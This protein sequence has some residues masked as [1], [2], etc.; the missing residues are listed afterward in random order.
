MASARLVEVRLDRFKSFQDAVLPL[1][2]VTVLT[3]RNSSGKSNVLDAIDVLARICG[4]DP[5]GDALDG[6]RREGGPV[7]GG[8]RGCAPYGAS[9]FRIGCRIETRE[10]AIDYEIEVEVDPIVRVRHERLATEGTRWF[11]VTHTGQGSLSVTYRNGKRG[12]DPQVDVRDD[13]SVLG[14]LRTAGLVEND[15][16]RELV[17][18]AATVA[19][20][21]SNAFH[22]DPVPQLMRTYVPP[23]E[24]RLRRSGENLAAAALAL[25]RGDEQRF[26]E[27]TDLVRTVA[28]CD[29]KALSFS[30]TDEGDVMLA[31]DEG[32]G[33]RT[34]AMLMS[35]GLLRFTAVATALLTASTSLDVDGPEVTVTGIG[36]PAAGPGVLLVV[37][38]IENGLHPSHAG[39]LLGLVEAA[40]RQPGASV[41]VTT[42]S[43]ALLD[44]IDPARLRDVV[45]CHAGQITRLTDLPGYAAAMAGGSLGTVV[46]QG[47]LV[48]AEAESE[49]DYSEFL[50]LIGAEP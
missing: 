23:R 31:L 30:T 21:L 5:L 8:S 26:E 13:R 34:T 47:R 7:R 11:E 10:S 44:R 15:T 24:S 3:G 6:R 43:P 25:Q 20:T 41:L 2:E 50:R 46:S 48:A 38:E 37:E 4:G 45:V 14:Q 39:L 40:G 27:L 35:D 12:R 18:H 22:L 16:M 33:R 29:V 1:G 36:A 17:A 19:G 32:H 42:H 28:D 49:P 9:S